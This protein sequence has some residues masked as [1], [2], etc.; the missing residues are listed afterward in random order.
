VARWLPAPGT[1][2]NQWCSR[3]WAQQQWPVT[4]AEAPEGEWCKA[5]AVTP[6][7]ESS[8]ADIVVVADADVW[9]DGISAAVDAIEGGAAWATPHLKVH[10]L[11]PEAT[12][13]ILT[14]GELHDRVPLTEPAYIGRV[15]GGI[16]AIRRDVYL[17][18][19]LD[20]RFI[21][22]GQEDEAWN[23]ALTALHGDV[24]QGVAPLYHLWHP[25][26]PRQ[27]RAIGSP[28]SA[29]LLRRY[30]ASRPAPTGCG[31]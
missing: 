20:P 1:R 28:R 23:L 14:G 17:D 6:A 9:C 30:K 22:W 21:G 7:V 5:A 29:A 27:S 24:H 16:L 3:R 26:Q 11:T 13:E 31:N 19:P 25:S 10:R 8:S 18:C 12:E 15:G 2:V 4:T